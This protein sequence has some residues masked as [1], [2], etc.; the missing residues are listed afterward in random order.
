M[1]GD[2]FRRQLDAAK[3]YAD[4]H[5]LALDEELT[6]QDLGV[7][8]YR[9]R[10]AERGSLADF[11]LAVQTRT[12]EP[13]SYLLV[14]SFDRLSRMDPW[15]ALPVF[16]EIINAGITIVTLQDG[17]EWNREGIR[18]NPFRIMESL[19]VMMRAH[20]ESQ[21]KARRL[22]EAWGRKRRD[23]DKVLLTTRCPAWLKAKG[24]RSGFNIIPERAAIVE[25]I[26]QMAAEGRGQHAITEM[27]NTERVPTWG[28]GQRR[29]AL[30]WHRSYV[31]KILNNPAVIGTLVPHVV[32]TDG[33]QKRRKAQPP[34]TGYYPAVVSEDL[35]R[36]VQALKTDVAS[37]L[38]GRHAKNGV[39]Q[40]VLGG[41]ARC[42]LCRGTMTRVSK[43]SRKKA[44]PAY[45]VCAKAKDGDGCDYRGVK[46]AAVEEALRGA[47]GL[48]C[49]DCPPQ[50]TEGNEL[51]RQIRGAEDQ[52]EATRQEI[53]R[54]VLSLRQGASTEVVRTIRELETNMDRLQAE[55]D[56]LHDK[57]AASLP[58]LLERRIE[59]L[60]AALSAEPFDRTT[61]NLRLRESFSAV[62]V[63]Y[64]RGQLGFTWKHGGSS[65][66]MFSWPADEE[67]LHD[68]AGS[69]PIGHLSP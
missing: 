55:L 9:G 13:G 56:A 61:A 11:R 1:K 38:R 21:T 25:R 8:A 31:A 6:F 68:S 49:D 66:V 16:Q 63:D 29:P 20:E 43:G 19:L 3:R 53:E 48:L 30:R 23:A 34:I 51:E 10:N 7:S 46:L 62:V 12:V 28:D 54:L 14:E 24:D 5:G 17:R 57:R 33:R 40:N 35:Y 67:E 18:A 15:E 22:K 4:R 32:E 59:D 27:L 65:S 58:A 64:R 41:L 2:S 69:P 39:I 60:E 37:P 47:A 42:P 50:G 36:R 44:G 52:I 45:L 26:Y